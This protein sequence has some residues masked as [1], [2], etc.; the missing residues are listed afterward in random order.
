MTIIGDPTHL[1]DILLLPKLSEI[2][3]SIYFF[4]GYTVDSYFP[5]SLLILRPMMK[6]SACMLCSLAYGEGAPDA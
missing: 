5:Y 6:N 2:S 3:I 1:V 4:T